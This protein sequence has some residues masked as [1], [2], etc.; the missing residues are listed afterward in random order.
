MTDDLTALP[1]LADLIDVLTLR[2]LGTAHISVTG[3]E[4]QDAASSIGATS[5]RVFEGRSQKMPH[6]R[7]FGG[8]VLAQCVMAA[9]LTVRDVV[10]DGPR[11]IHSLHGYFMRP[12]DDTLPIR[13]AVEEMRDGASFS[14]RRVHAIQKGAPIMSMTCS[15]QER[16]GGLDHQDPM[17]EVPGPDELRSLSDV[18]GGIDHPGAK[19]IAESRPIEQRHVEG[20]VFL[21][22]G[23]E[24][25]AEQHVWMRAIG[26]LPDDQL[27]HSAVLAYASDY[28]LLEPIL[29]RHGVVW[30]DPRLRAASL[31]H[32]MWFHR[33]VDI[34]D[35]VLYAQQSPSAISG[36]GLGIGQMFAQD[37]RLVAT[38]AQ[39]GMIRLKES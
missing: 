1:P 23:T 16:A 12:G 10:G 21:D 7:V 2:E 5:A 15:F 19:H 30:T 17:P 37:G 32:S 34:S 18:F 9:G 24:R 29:R 22:A 39:E 38:T 36:R 35:W 20:S 8:Q 31:D 14:T 28:T 3:I 33:D 25:V 4:G 11:P 6:G 13:F 26:E 27:L